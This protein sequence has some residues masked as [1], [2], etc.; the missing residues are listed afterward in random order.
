MLRNRSGPITS[1][2]SPS[3]RNISAMVLS[4]RT[5]PLTC[6]AQASVTISRRSGASF[7]G[8]SARAR[9]WSG[10]GNGQALG[11]RLPLGAE[12]RLTH[13]VDQLEAAIGMLDEGGA[14]FHPIAVVH[15]GDAVDLAHL[16]VMDVAADDAVEA[17]PSRLVGERQ[18]EPVDRLHCLL[19]LP[20]QPL[21]QRPVGITELATGGVE[22]TVQGERHVVG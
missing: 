19:H 9:G 15:V 10:T 2:V 22:P 11:G 8:A 18:L 6:G 14:A 3:A 21:R 20:L 1:T 12:A 7:A 17:A 13:P 16:G 4:V 5:T